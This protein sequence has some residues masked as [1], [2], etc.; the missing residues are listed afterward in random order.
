M[1]VVTANW[2]VADGSLVMRSRHEQVEWLAAVRRAAIRAG[3]R[4]DGGYAPLERVDVVLAGD[5]LDALT[6]SAW[7]GRVRPWHEG[8]RAAEIADRVLVAAAA[9]GRRLLGG[10]ARWAREG[11]VVPAADGRGR[12]DWSRL[13]R[14][15]VHVAALPGDR[16][17]RIAAALPRLARRGISV[18]ATWS[19]AGI[20]VC[21]GAELDP[22]WCGGGPPEPGRPTLGESLAVDLV[23]RF[24]AALHGDATWP[25]ARGLVA[26]LASAPPLDLP[27]IVSAWIAAATP[28][29]ALAV[30][31]RWLAAVAGW[32]RAARLA[33]PA[34]AAACAPLDAVAAW[35]EGCGGPGTAAR[36]IEPLFATTMPPQAGA[37][38]VLGHPPSARSAGAVVCLG[39]PRGG[40]FELEARGA[41][42]V[43]CVA[44]MRAA[45]GPLHVVFPR[46]GTPAV[47][48]WLGGDAAADATASI[49]SPAAARI[50]EA[51]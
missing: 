10:L 6:S 1:L 38:L 45:G 37:A 41:A 22:A 3:V 32:R 27:A 39:G 34:C 20:T 50:V 24:G 26:G 40:T 28:P 8:R 18:A 35:L 9:R 19:G 36:E 48:T 21:H 16:D 4:G 23:A 25:A 7:L 15:P 17:R 43:A 11:L 12:P 5:T 30:R 42:T 49:G 2:A 13:L 29:A 14:V 31:D 47:W 44:P 46:T 51:A 33:E